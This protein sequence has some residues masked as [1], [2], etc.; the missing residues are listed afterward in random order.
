M[1]YKSVKNGNEDLF[2][3]PGIG[4]DKHNLLLIFSIKL[5]INGIQ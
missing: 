3:Q 5:N 4:S 2:A 1:N